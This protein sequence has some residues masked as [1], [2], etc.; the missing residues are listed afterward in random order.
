MLLLDVVQYSRLT[1]RRYHV[2]ER[3]YAG[4][5]DVFYWAGCIAMNCARGG[6][7]DFYAALKFDAVVIFM[8]S[9]IITIQIARRRRRHGGRTP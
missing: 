3:F 1:R 6:G 8:E 2:L 7:E 5:D 9:G 4:I